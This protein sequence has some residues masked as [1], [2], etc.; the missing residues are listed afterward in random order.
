MTIDKEMT[1]VTLKIVEDARQHMYKK[2][3]LTQC[4][5]L[6]RET[7]ENIGAFEEEF[8]PNQWSE[9]SYENALWKIKKSLTL[10]KKELNTLE[11]FVI[12]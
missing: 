7:M 6:L 12:V 11:G 4:K 8:S 1:D 5:M 9:D 10:L 2:H 3:S